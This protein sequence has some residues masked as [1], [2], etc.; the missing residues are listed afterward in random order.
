MDYVHGVQV[1]EP[2]HDLYG[3]FAHQGFIELAEPVENLPDRTSRYHLEDNVN[4]IIA[5]TLQTVILDNVRVLQ[6]L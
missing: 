1:F 3:I 6:I 5:M 4:F 2:F